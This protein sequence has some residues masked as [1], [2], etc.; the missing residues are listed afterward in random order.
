MVS[1]D[2]AVLGASAG[3]GLGGGAVTW[4][5][6]DDPEGRSVAVAVDE[7]WFEIDD[8]VRDIDE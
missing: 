2:N 3:G 8:V 1:G 6:R 5:G 4:S 7:S